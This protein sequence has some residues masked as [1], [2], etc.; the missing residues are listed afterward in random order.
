[1]I[2]LS[3]LEDKYGDLP[4]AVLGGGPSLP[5][6]VE[7]LP[8]LLPVAAVIAVNS[9]AL[10]YMTCDYMV[11]LDG[12]DSGGWQHH[13]DMI[14]DAEAE[15]VRVS[16]LSQY[17]DV[18]INVPYWHNAG[19]SG[20]FATWLACYLT[21]GP[22]ILGGMD[23][24]QGDDKYPYVGPPIRQGMHSTVRS[25]LKSWE[26]AI[27]ECRNSDR[28]LVMGGPLVRFFKPCYPM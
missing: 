18:D 11:F 28:I 12:P 24:Y 27:R 22:V 4:V 7:Q 2:K 5:L 17:S 23:L 14:S 1:M 8:T 6:H 3:D 15:Y 19:F 20:G 25:Q 21:R 16:P 26:P 10:R 13:A 9:H